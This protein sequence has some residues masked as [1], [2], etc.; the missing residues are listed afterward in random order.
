M[1]EELVESVF[2]AKKEL[3]NAAITAA[4]L[5]ELRKFSVTAKELRFL[6]VGNFGLEH[7]NAE[8]QTALALILWERLHLRAVTAWDPN[9]KKRDLRALSSLGIHVKE[10]DPQNAEGLLWFVPHAP[11]FLEPSLLERIKSDVYIGNDLSRSDANTM[12]DANN[13]AWYRDIAQISALKVKPKDPWKEAFKNTA[14]HQLQPKEG[15]T[16]ENL[17]GETIH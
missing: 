2:N 7:K 10:K 13:C 11:Y 14:I 15:S 4:L 9:F 17:V 1:E 8:Y 12:R 5:K 3:E 6:A 16:K